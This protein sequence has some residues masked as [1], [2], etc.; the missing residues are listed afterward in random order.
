MK[1]HATSISN[2]VGGLIEVIEMNELKNTFAL[3]VK[4]FR[5]AFSKSA[6]MCIKSQSFHQF[7]EQI[8]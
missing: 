3:K 8:L 6:E 7:P 4:M 1:S 2:R 5:E